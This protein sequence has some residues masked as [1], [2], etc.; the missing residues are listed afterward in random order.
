MFFE[1]GTLASD[2]KKRL[3]VINIENFI[4]CVISGGLA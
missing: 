4:K 2:D 1:I 3:G